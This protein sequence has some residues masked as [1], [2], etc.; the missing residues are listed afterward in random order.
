MPFPIFKLTHVLD[1]WF[2]VIWNSQ[3]YVYDGV[4]ES[5]KIHP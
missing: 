3:L 1:T 5:Y 4:D 2:F